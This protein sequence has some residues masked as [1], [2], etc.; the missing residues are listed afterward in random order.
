MFFEGIHASPCSINQVCLIP[1]GVFASVA[2]LLLTDPLDPIR[3]SP[4]PVPLIVRL[5][6]YTLEKVHCKKV[7]MQV[8]CYAALEQVARSTSGF[9]GAELANV[10]NE[11]AILAAR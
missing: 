1:A 10:V 4:L 5:A 8:E 3:S 2:S 11:A 6:L 9:S 7:R